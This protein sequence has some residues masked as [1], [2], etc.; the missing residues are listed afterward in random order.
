MRATTIE[1]NESEREMLRSWT[2]NGKTEQR[3][4]LRAQIILLADE[5]KATQEIAES[6][7]IRHLKG[8]SGNPR[9]LRMSPYS[10]LR[11]NFF[12]DLSVFSVHD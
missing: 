11:H 1:L 8:K 6:L 7:S 5:G 2:R 4:S 10:S 3:M 12:I 9:R